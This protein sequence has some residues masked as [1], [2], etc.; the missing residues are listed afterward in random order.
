MNGNFRKKTN[1]DWWK[2]LESAAS[3]HQVT[4]EWTRG[5][6]GHEV[7]EVADK[8]ARAIAALG[9]VD[10]DLLEDAVVEIGVREV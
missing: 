3:K 10:H 6:S 2:K 9:R 7:Q 1:L 5:H 8:T 4:W